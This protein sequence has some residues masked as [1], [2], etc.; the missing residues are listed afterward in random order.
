MNPTPRLALIEDHQDLREEILLY[1]KS[2]GFEVWGVGSAEDFY[3]ALTWQ[4]ADIV[5]VD[6][7]LPG[8]DGLQVIEHLRQHCNCGIIAVT[9]RGKLEDRLLGLEQGVDYYL[10]KPVDLEELVATIQTMWRRMRSQQFSAP[11]AAHAPW[12]MDNTA[13]ALLCP[14][15]AA[16]PLTD[17]EY[18]VLEHLLQY[19]GQVVSKEDLHEVVFPGSGMVEPHRIEVI[20]SRAR[21]KAKAA[22]IQLPIRA[23]FGKGLVFVQPG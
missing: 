19:S 18:T 6:L 8:E 13:R 23:V 2:Q 15:G 17:K 20:L 10:V 14:T 9:A 22:G 7:T 21:K 5:L 16:L 3:K 12:R 4:Q 11:L 1:L